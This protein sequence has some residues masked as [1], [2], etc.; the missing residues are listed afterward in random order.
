MAALE[1]LERGQEPAE[2]SEIFKSMQT[3]LGRV[4]NI[5]RLMGHAPTVL[6]VVVEFSRALMRTKLDAQLRELAYI[7][8]SL[9]NECEYCAHHHMAL[10][11]K[12]GLTDTKIEALD[13]YKNS[14]Q[15]TD[16]EKLVLRYAEDLT[17]EVKSDRKVMEALKQYLSPQELVEL[18]ATVGLANMTNR[19]NES[20]GTDLED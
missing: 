1:Y 4:P 10:G 13:D 16:L 9:V 20:F 19:F 8:T 3:K 12:A 17:R 15:F 14:D 18:N 5:Y 11:R 7:K 6:G 2:A